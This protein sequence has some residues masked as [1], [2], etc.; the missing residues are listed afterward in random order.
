MASFTD[1]Q[2]RKWNLVLTV[3]DVKRVRKMLDFDLL[4]DDMGEMIAELSKDQVTFCDVLYVLLK[5]DADTAGVTDEEFGRSM[6]GD[7]LDAALKAFF[8][9]FPLF[10][11]NP[12]DRQNV[13]KF[14]GK[15]LELAETARDEIEGAIARDLKTIDDAVASGALSMTPQESQESTPQDSAFGS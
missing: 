14:L 5:P 8:E 15:Y 6:S 9:A 3:A 13:A 4:R 11:P 7:S 10:F 12:R 1:T 2:G